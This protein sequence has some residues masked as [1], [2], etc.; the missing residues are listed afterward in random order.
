MVAVTDFD[1]YA[2]LAEG[3]LRA[4]PQPLPVRL[5]VV[6]TREANPIAV[7]LLALLRLSLG[8][9]C[10]SELVELLN[11]A[12]VQHH[13]ELAG[14]EEALAQLAD[15]IRQSGLTHGIDAADR[16]AGGDTGT[17]R[18][19]LDRLL[20]GAW[21][22]PEAEAK[23]AGGNLVHAV[24]ADLHHRDEIPL[25]FV[26]WLTRLACQ[27]QTWRDPAPAAEW[28]GRLQK[29]VD[30]LLASDEHD[31]H[32]AAMGRLLGELAAVRADTPLRRRGDVRL[33]GAAAR[34]RHEPAHQHGWR[35]PPRPA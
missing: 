13:L 10:A 1:A 14:E 2:P 17:W 27:L 16:G 11:L 19:A 15:A 6:P 29:A 32:A 9:H 18:A 20:A 3:I 4:G 8:R 23:D 31:D 24:A 35:N 33:A 12:A 7:G 34:K 21:F 22:G 30:D 5:T 26:G 25:R 28:A